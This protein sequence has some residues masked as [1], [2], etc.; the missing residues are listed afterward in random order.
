MWLNSADSKREWE[1]L[2]VIE[3]NCGELAKAGL[4]IGVYSNLLLPYHLSKL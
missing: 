4:E 1:P 3:D 2:I